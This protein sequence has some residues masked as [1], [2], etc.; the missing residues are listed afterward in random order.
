[1]ARDLASAGRRSRNACPSL[2]L[3]L[4]A[5]GFAL[6]VTSAYHLGY[7][8]FQGPKLAQANLGNAIAT[9]P[10]LL[11]GNPLAS[12]LAHALLHIAAVVH[13]P[14]SELFLPPH[15]VASA[16]RGKSE[17]T[18]RAVIEFPLHDT[19]RVCQP[20]GHERHAFDFVPMADDDGYFSRPWR[21]Y[22]LGAGPAS[23]WHGWAQ[24]VFAPF[25]GTVVAACDGSPDR[26]TVNLVR[27][28]RY[29]FSLLFASDR[30]RHS[31]LRG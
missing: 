19:W 31:G 10:T 5:L 17:V 18:E 28:V 24:P 2:G 7:P 25:D 11:S 1:V 9:L 8:D 12:P 29:P 22:L 14:Q 13:D 23:A 15:G 27:D 6:P 20:P 3:G 30:R 16:R 21:A 26:G 4:V